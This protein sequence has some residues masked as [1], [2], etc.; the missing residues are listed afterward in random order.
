MKFAIA[1]LLG[2]AAA[3]MTMP[4][5]TTEAMLK[6]PNLVKDLIDTA[7]WGAASNVVFTQCA[8]DAGVFTLSTDDTTATPNP[9]AKNA[10]VALHISGITAATINQDKVHVHV[11]WNGAPLYDHDDST[12][13]TYDSAV[14]Y[15]YKWNIPPIAPNGAYDVVLTG[16]DSTG[17]KQFCVE[18]K[19][20]F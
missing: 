10:D 1:A 18:A 19:F 12:Q 16:L 3:E 15:D 13:A 17:K 8:D 9:P 6:R 11:N 14:T 4:L 2:S 7:G 5:F 20:S